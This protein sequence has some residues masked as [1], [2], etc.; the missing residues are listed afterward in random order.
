[1]SHIWQ[2]V[3]FPLRFSNVKTYISVAPQPVLCLAGLPD[4]VVDGVLQG[5]Y[6]RDVRV[7][8]TASILTDSAP[9]PSIV[10]WNI[11]KYH[12]GPL[13]NI[14]H[15]LASWNPWP[16]VPIWARSGTDSLFGDKTL[17][18]GYNVLYTQWDLNLK[19]RLCCLDHQL[20]QT[21]Q[22]REILLKLGSV[23]TRS[24]PVCLW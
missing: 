22:T 11:Q 2:T 7:S 9:V 12:P 13:K 6:P 10:V 4:I 24:H 15:H 16:Q 21:H 23:C 20:N 18:P 1:M 5:L 19:P 17:Y 14:V 3:F 8:F